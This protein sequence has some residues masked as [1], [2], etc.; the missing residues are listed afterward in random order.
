MRVVATQRKR[1]GD[2][3]AMSCVAEKFTAEHG[4]LAPRAQELSPVVPELPWQE[5]VS[6]P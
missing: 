5:A 3:P 2:L 6:G 1:L 4:R